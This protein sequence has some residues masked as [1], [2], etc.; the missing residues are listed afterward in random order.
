MK[1]VSLMVTQMTMLNVNGTMRSML[2][3]FTTPCGMPPTH[4][5]RVRLPAISPMNSTQLVL[6]NGPKP[7]PKQSKKSPK[8]TF[9]CQKSW[10]TALEALM[11]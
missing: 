2:T 1:V 9:P 7:S 5:L 6:P 11:L 3:S 10:K 4:T 8:T